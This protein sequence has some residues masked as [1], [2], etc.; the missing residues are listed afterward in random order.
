M[1]GTVLDPNDKKKKVALLSWYFWLTRDTK[2]NK[3]CLKVNGQYKTEV[4]A[5]EEK[6]EGSKSLGYGVKCKEMMFKLSMEFNQA[7][8]RESME[9]LMGRSVSVS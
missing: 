2:M 6:C 1:L 7:K 4:N 8:G 9:S 5:M 3:T